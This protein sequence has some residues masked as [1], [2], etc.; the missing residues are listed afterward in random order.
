M[1]SLATSDL[2]V[3]FRQEMFAWLGAK[4]TGYESPTSGNACRDNSVKKEL[5]H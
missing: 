1:R 3:D 2:A 5:I 4:D